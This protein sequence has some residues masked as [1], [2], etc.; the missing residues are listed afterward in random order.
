[1]FALADAEPLDA[2]IARAQAAETHRQAQQNWLPFPPRRVRL[3]DD[4]PSV[5]PLIVPLGG[6]ADGGCDAGGGG[7]DGG[8]S[9]A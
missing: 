1:M 6:D 2:M 4:G 5:A 7:G 9:A 3:P 8:S